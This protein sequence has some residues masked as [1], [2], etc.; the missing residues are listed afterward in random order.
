ML[1]GWER[2]FFGDTSPL[3]AED[4]DADTWDH[5]TES[6]FGTDPLSADTDGDGVQDPA[7]ADPLD[8]SVQ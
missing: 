1:D 7:D 5:F 3:G 2:L 4:P 8:A 6:Q